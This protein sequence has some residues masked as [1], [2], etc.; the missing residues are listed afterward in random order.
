MLTHKSMRMFQDRLRVDPEQRQRLVIGAIRIKP[1]EHDLGPPETAAAPEALPLQ[2]VPATML[3]G[4]ERQM[5]ITSGRA[6]PLSLSS[7]SSCP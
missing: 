3:F 4:H 7:M 5:H 1:V 2:R 6:G